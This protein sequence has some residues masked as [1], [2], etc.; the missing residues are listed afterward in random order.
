MRFRVQ[1]QN[2]EGENDEDVDEFEDISEL[3]DREIEKLNRKLE[4][5]D[6]DELDQD[7][8]S[9]EDSDE[10]GEANYYKENIFNK[11]DVCLYR[12]I[13]YIYAE[14]YSKAINDLEAC[15]NIMH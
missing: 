10:G 14:E 2:G 9:V 3:D 13:L 7:D 4:R 11:E 6:S 15:S 5:N 1:Q 8:T 12:G